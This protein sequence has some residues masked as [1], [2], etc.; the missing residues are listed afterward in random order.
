M[1]YAALFGSALLAATLLPAQSEALLVALLLDGTHDWHWLLI[2]A[3]AGNTLG[4]SIN[5]L[6]GR[7]MARFQNHRWFPVSPR[8]YERGHRWFRRYGVWSLLFSWLPFVGD[9]LTV[10]AGV[11]GVSLWTFVVLVAIGKAARYVAVV[12]A[13]LWWI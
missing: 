6:L 7:F 8:T 13:T 2:V 9:P 4:A 5:W 1:S 11:L 12:A 10:A 3:T